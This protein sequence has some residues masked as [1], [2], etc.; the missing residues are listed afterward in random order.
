[1]NR[2]DGEPLVGVGT[3]TGTR[4]GHVLGLPFSGKV[5]VNRVTPDKFSYVVNADGETIA[6]LTFRRIRGSIEEVDSARELI[7]HIRGGTWHMVS[8]NSRMEDSYQAILG[9]R[10]TRFYSTGNSQI[11]ETVGILGTHPKNNQLMWWTFRK[12]GSISI[13]PTTIAKQSSA[14]FTALIGSKDHPIDLKV[15]FT[16]EDP[17]H[18]VLTTVGNVNGGKIPENNSWERRYPAEASWVTSDPPNEIPAALSKLKHVT[19]PRWITLESA[20][21]GKG[22]GSSM[23][24]WILGGKFFMYTANAVYENGDDWGHCFI[25]GHDSESGSYKGWEFGSGGAVGEF[26]LSEDGMSLKGSLIERDSSG[27]VAMNYQGSFA[28]DGK[29]WRY[30]A[31]IGPKGGTA[32]PYV[33]TW[34]EVGK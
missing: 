8:P 3:A 21:T 2:Y 24:R 27:E 20:T 7:N 4:V 9:G 17:N 26:V 1:M 34:R 11:P 18:S 28:L 25:L 29:V 23:G 6:D 33:W 31:K 30:T 14:R 32:E 12:D 22:T 19:G 15:G 16:I 5:D 13:V 10:F